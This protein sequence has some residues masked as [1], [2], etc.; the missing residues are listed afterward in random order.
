MNTI[1]I[2]KIKAGEDTLLNSKNATQEIYPTTKF[3]TRRNINSEVIE[4]DNAFHKL[5]CII[6]TR[7]IPDFSVLK[8]NRLFNVYS[9]IKLRKN[10]AD[11]PPKG[12][13]VEDSLEINEDH[14]IYRPIF[15]MYL[16]NYKCSKIKDELHSWKFEFEEK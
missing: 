3:E 8:S 9:I 1:S 7:D 14:V 11:P 6:E 16:I 15:E 12:S 4:Q 13:Y 2:L 10:S 5:R